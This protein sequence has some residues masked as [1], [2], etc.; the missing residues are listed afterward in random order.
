MP[1]FSSSDQ[2]ASTLAREAIMTTTFIIAAIVLALMA[3][4]H[5]QFRA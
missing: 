4:G 1:A 3:L 5:I 2:R